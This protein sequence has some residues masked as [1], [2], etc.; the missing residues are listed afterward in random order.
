MT[1]ESP[2]D[3]LLAHYGKNT[4]LIRSLVQLIPFGIGGAADV[5]LT[6]RLDV[7]R[8]DR[9]R[10]FFDQLSSGDLELSAELINSEDFLH[11]FYATTNAALNTRR[12]EKIILF[13][14]LLKSAFAKHSPRDTD[15][16]EELLGIL[17]DITLSEWKALLLLDRYSHE[18]RAHNENIL[19][20]SI[21]F[22]KLFLSDVEQQLAMPREETTF[23]LNRIA[24]TGLYEQIV[25]SYL[26]YS[27]GIGYLTPR[28]HRLK[29]FVEE[30]AEA[31]DTKA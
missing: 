18:P 15:E 23:F 17:D 5:A 26:D 24:R 2:I 25:G 20:W 30:K 21:K 13:A 28:F 9:T 19:Q 8:A 11:C 16:Y 1:G 29:S 31:A 22:W 27:G 10:I 4:L 3:K 12:H 14:N 6:R 7:I